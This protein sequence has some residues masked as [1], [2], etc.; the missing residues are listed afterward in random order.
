MNNSMVKYLSL[1]FLSVQTASHVLITRYSRTADTSHPYLPRTTVALVEVTK[2]L[3]CIAIHFCNKGF[4]ISVTFTSILDE[5]VRKPKECLK[6]SVPALL[7][8]CQNCLL[9]VAL[10]NLNSAT[11][12]V[13]YQLKILT[14]ALFSVFM[15]SKRLSST[16]WL[17]LLL[18]TI[19]VVLVQVMKSEDDGSM[20]DSTL[21]SVYAS[22]MAV[23]LASCLSGFN[24]VY[25]EKVL[26][27]SKQSLWIRNIQ[28]AGA[29]ILIAF[30]SLYLFDYE[31]IQ[32]AG[33]FQGYTWAT[34]AVICLSVISGLTVAIVVKYADNILKGFAVSIS[35]LISTF[36]SFYFLD[37][38]EPNFGF[39]LGAPMVIGATFLYG[40]NFEKAKPA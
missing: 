33:F 15:L 5:V 27:S 12:Q 2:L 14:T 29:S 28:L 3:I 11:Y 1:C 22:M 7:Y 30:T 20:S 13:C 24:G 40:M 21:G 34:W 8:V 38:F 39:F 18:L 31:A 32:T 9:F 36:I 4:R 26:K 16:Q 19:G 23:L 37:D 35:I 6:L 25:F 17:A 10:S